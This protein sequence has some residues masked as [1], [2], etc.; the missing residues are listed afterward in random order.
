MLSDA[1]L[2]SRK[3]KKKVEIRI[4]QLLVKRDKKMLEI[5]YGTFQM[6]VTIYDLR[7]QKNVTLL[8]A[9]KVCRLKCFLATI[10]SF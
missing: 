3:S 8:L 4:A 5:L 9:S 10:A 2:V 1:G 6:E 7:I